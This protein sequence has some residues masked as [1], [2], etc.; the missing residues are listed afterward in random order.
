[1]T[2]EQQVAVRLYN[3]QFLSKRNFCE[4]NTPSLDFPNRKQKSQKH[5]QQMFLMFMKHSGNKKL[6]E[7]N[8]ENLQKTFRANTTYTTNS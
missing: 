6:F 7:L 3:D 2:Q 5:K 1:M 8:N 4:K